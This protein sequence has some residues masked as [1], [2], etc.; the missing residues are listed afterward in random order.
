MDS[1]GVVR[2]EDPECAMCPDNG[3]NV[4]RV[5][6]Y[7]V[8]NGACYDKAGKLRANRAGHGCPPAGCLQA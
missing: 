5:R 7:V 8:A 4:R 3:R 1:K 6:K 2:C